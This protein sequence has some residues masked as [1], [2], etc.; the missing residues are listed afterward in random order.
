MFTQ[1]T[2]LDALQIYGGAAIADLVEAKIAEGYAP[3]AAL[4]AA[5]MYLTSKPATRTLGLS[6]LARAGMNSVKRLVNP[7]PGTM[8]YSLLPGSSDRTFFTKK[9][10]G[11]KGMRGMGLTQ[12]AQYLKSQLNA[13]APTRALPAPVMDAKGLK[14][15]L[16]N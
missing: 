7:T 1:K 9:M 16:A 2:L 14:Y 10:N 15:L 11:M 3:N 4:I 6:I 8:A 12:G 13:P 5:A